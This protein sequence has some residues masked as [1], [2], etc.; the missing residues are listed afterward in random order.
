MTEAEGLAPPEVEQLV[1]YPIETAMNGMPGV[2]RVRSTSGVGLSIVLCRIRLGHRCL[3]QPAAGR[4]NGCR[5]VGRATAGSASPGDGT[6]SLHHGRDHADRAD[7]DGDG[8]LQWRREYADSSCGHGCCRLPASRRSSDW[9]RSAQFR[10]ALDTGA[11]RHLDITVGRSSSALGGSAAN[12]GGGFIDLGDSGIFHSPHRPHDAIWRSL[13]DRVV[14]RR[15]APGSSLASGE[16]R[17][18]RRA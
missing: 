15:R 10:V 16:R 7:R 4:P 6:N 13:R 8:R 12:A 17:I 2:T 14:A 1:T 5:V 3:S 18:C 11:A 9:R